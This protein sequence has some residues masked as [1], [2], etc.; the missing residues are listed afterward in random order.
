MYKRVKDANCA[1]I[2][3][4]V[5]TCEIVTGTGDLANGIFRLSGGLAG[6]KTFKVQDWLKWR[7]LDLSPFSSRKK[8][9]LNTTQFD[10]QLSQKRKAQ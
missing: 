9:K 2:F 5:A 10:P 1:R 8:R 6:F 7:F 4:A 3:A